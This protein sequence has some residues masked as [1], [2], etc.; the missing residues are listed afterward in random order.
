MNDTISSFVNETILL[1]KSRYE[2]ETGKKFS[3][4]LY[5]K[6]DALATTEHPATYAFTMTKLPKIGLNPKTSFETPAG[7]YFYPL[8]KQYLTKLV[9]NTL[10]F[11]SDNPYFGVVK[12]KYLDETGKWLKFIHSGVSDLH[13][14]DIYKA[15]AGCRDKSVFL[16][17]QKS[18]KHWNFNTDAKIFDLGYFSNS[19]GTRN[20]TIAW[21]NWLR[22]LGYVGIYDAG[23]GIIHPS[24]PTQLVCLSPEAYETIGLWATQELRK[25]SFADFDEYFDSLTA[26]QQQ[27]AVLYN[28]KPSVKML[29]K[30]AQS[31]N[32]TT[33]AAVARNDK[34]PASVLEM[35][36]NDASLDVRQQ[37]AGNPNLTFDMLRKML[38]RDDVRYFALRHKNLPIDVLAKYTVKTADASDRYAACNNPNISVELLA[39][40][41]DDPTD[42]VRASV[43]KNKKATADMLQQLSRDSHHVVRMSVASNPNTPDDILKSLSKDDNFDV[44][45]VTKNSVKRRKY[46]AA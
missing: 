26:E 42:Y 29:S 12:L 8:T 45:S 43:A 28:S 5:K 25:K 30:L 37:A 17:A 11:V 15:L 4:D 3:I 38:S 44:R 46:Q 31:N 10:P 36:L 20:P 40:L 21:N 32:T 6:L 22:K 18:G 9:N 34:T 14:D 16:H 27:D 1:E 23:H 39:T 24:E 2:K 13:D 33:R 7:V 41:V 35:L 19:N